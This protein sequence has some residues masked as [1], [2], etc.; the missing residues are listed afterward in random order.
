MVKKLQ[1][2]LVMLVIVLFIVSCAPKPSAPAA[3]PVAET[4]AITTGEAPIDEVAT[5]I[6]TSADIEEELDT[7]KLDDIDSILADIENI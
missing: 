2:S 3:P 4:P 1:I 5:D 6:S 7:S